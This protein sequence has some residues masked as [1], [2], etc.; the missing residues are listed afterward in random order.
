MNCFLNSNS[1]IE[2][3]DIDIWHYRKWNSGFVELYGFVTKNLNIACYSGSV[4][5]ADEKNCE[6]ALPFPLK[7]S[8]VVQASASGHD[9]AA[10]AGQTYCNNSN[11][12]VYTDVMAGSAILTD[13]DI[14]FYIAGMWK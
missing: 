13:V 1:I 4:Y 3:N 6:T 12:T 2:E 11:D 14:S 7:T 10:W 5:R 8:Y 9:I